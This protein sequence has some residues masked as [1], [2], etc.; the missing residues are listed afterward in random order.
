MVVHA[1]ITKL[2]S[3]NTDSVYCFNKEFTTEV[4]YVILNLLTAPDCKVRHAFMF[5]RDLPGYS[6]D[7]ATK[8]ELVLSP[9]GVPVSFD[10]PLMC[11]E[12]TFTGYL[13]KNLTMS[14]PS[15]EDV[16]DRSVDPIFEHAWKL[17]HDDAARL[18]E[19]KKIS[20]KFLD[21]ANESEDEEDEESKKG[22]MKMVTCSNKK[23]SSPAW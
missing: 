18:A 6:L 22:T 7:K 23:C 8:W 4:D 14:P 3:V 16:N 19:V 12:Q 1:D 17:L 10:C 13:F 20:D 11:G 5:T 21:V 2:K 9:E 15:D